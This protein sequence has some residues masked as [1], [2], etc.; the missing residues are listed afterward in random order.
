MNKFIIGF[1][2]LLVGLGLGFSIPHGAQQP[3]AKV[4]GLVNNLAS[5][6]TSGFYAGTTD[7][8]SVSSAGALSTS[9]GITSTGAVVASSAVNKG[10]LTLVAG[11][12]TTTVTSGAICVASNTTASS[13]VETYASTTGA[14]LTVKGSGTNQVNYF[15]W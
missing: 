6:F 5:H 14:T 1:L 8:F 13:T 9:G 10:T 11:T 7:Q 2:S 4:G 15:C 3:V 12:A